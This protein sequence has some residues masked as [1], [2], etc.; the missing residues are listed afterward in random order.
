V[1]AVFI[2]F[3]MAVG[4]W[5]RAYGEVLTGEERQ[6]VRALQDLSL[7]HLEL[8]TPRTVCCAHEKLVLYVSATGDVTPCPFV[9]F[10]MGNIRERPLAEM[11]RRYCA[12]MKLAYRGDCPMNDPGARDAFRRHV[13]S[14]AAAF[15]PSGGAP[16]E[17]G[18]L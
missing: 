17:E 12:G 15:G 2:F 6:R 3:P 18:A 8:P 7:V 13:E 10:V 14:V 11:W 5:D 16:T 9:P 4:R 1:L